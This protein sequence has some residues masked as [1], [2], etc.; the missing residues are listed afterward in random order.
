MFR[1]S[2]ETQQGPTQKY[3]AQIYT[4][5]SL[6]DASETTRETEFGFLKD[7]VRKLVFALEDKAV[8]DLSLEPTNIPTSFVTEVPG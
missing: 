6:L 2:Q 1:Q 3:D 7:L 8:T 4:I 5:K